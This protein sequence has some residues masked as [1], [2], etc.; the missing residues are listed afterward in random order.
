MGVWC[1]VYFDVFC[2]GVDCMCVVL[3]S[4][5]GC[6]VVWWGGVVCCVAVLALSKYDGKIDEMKEREREVEIGR[7][8]SV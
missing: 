2:G 6:C 8:R 4:V 5:W 1:V 7:I 3:C